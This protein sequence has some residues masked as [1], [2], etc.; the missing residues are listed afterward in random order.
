[1]RYNRTGKA[2]RNWRRTTL[3]AYAT[4][5]MYKNFVRKQ[6]TNGKMEMEMMEESDRNNFNDDE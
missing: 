2:W 4:I 5:K 1:M 3:R 6:E